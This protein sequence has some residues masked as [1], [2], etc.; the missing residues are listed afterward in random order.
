MA[1]GLSASPA[2]ASASGFVSYGPFTVK[3]FSIGA[4]VLTH[5]IW[6]KGRTVDNQL[7]TLFAAG[8]VCNTQLFVQD[9]KDGK[10]KKEI[11]STYWQ[12]CA[13]GAS[14]AL[15]TGSRTIA[16]GIN[17]SCGQVRFSGVAKARQCHH[18]H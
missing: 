18:I 3:G 17:Q 6:G 12:G 9:L 8:Q 5:D 7:V 2:M 16:K 14:A 15:A 4:G 1:L 10:V 13:W 11:P